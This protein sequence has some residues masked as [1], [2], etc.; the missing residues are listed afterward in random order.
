MVQSRI[1]AFLHRRGG[2]RRKGDPVSL[3]IVPSTTFRLP[4]DP[5][6]THVYGRY[7][8]PTVEETEDGLG[9]LEDA[10]CIL[11]PSGMAA[12]AALFYAHLRPG[13]TVLVHSDGYYN[14]R[15]L[16]ETHLAPMGIRVVTCPTLQM[17]DADLTGIRMVLAETPSNPGLD[18]CDLQRLSHNARA[19]GALLAVDNTTATPLCQ[20]PLDLGADFSVMADTKAMAGHSDV[21]AGHVASRN[22]DLIAPI[23]S[24]RRL[25][26]AIVSPFDAF[27]LHRGLATLEVRVMRA[28]ATA[29]ALAHALWACPG[30]TGL[31][32]PG[33][34]SDPCHKVA[35]AQMTGY[36]PIVSFC[37][38]S[39]ALAEQFIATHPMLTPATSF[40]GVHASA[41]CR[42][43]WGDPVPEGFIRLS[44]GLEPSA[45]FVSA[46]LRTLDALELQPR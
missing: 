13:D 22:P 42:I 25:A 24:W 2:R 46:T 20:R 37:L 28:N 15:A 40:G 8:N 5:D 35:R 19:A 16:L 9:L 29:L 33:L 31:R 44:C 11:F 30:V 36:G 38:P 7:G 45:E 10:R 14:V 17:A 43:R 41:E 34:P 27:L 26:G 23:E 21:L 6:A 18:V 32:Y 39:R 3:P 4:G 12:L 1:T